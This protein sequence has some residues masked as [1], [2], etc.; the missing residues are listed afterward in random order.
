M[1]TI[2]GTCNVI[3]YDKCII[4]III[5]IIIITINSLDQRAYLEAV[6]QS[7]T[8]IL[9]STNDH[10]NVHKTPKVPILSLPH[11]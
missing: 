10:Y 9:R 1:V 7:N 11:S 2:Y 4:I 6:T 8:R 5:I 3:S